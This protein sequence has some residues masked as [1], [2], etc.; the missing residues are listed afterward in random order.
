MTHEDY[1]PSLEEY[2]DVEEV[3]WSFN[4]DGGY[5]PLLKESDVEK[6][7]DGCNDTDNDYEE[8]VVGCNDTD[9][10]YEENVCECYEPD[11]DYDLHCSAGDEYSDS[12]I[13]EHTD[14]D[15]NSIFYVDES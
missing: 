14:C 10:D 6:N 13:R 11:Y 12:M 8:N 3:S 1:D 2:D 9:N 15:S 4:P 5:I 7:V